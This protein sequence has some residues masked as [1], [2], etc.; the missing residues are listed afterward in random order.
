MLMP[1]V[2]WKEIRLAR[3][4][5]KQLFQIFSRAKK[6]SL[7]LHFC[8]PCETSTMSK[9]GFMNW[10]LK[11][12]FSFFSL[13]LFHVLASASEQP[14]IIFILSDDQGS[15][16]VGWRGSEIKTPHLDKLARAG[17]RLE[18]FYVQPLCSPTRAA[19]LTGRYPMRYGLQL[20]VIRPHS[21]YG[22]SLEE[23][24]LPQALREAGYTTALSGK[25]HLGT[26]TKDY[27]PNQR[28]FEHAYG[29]LFGMT[30]YFE[31]TRDGKL[32][33]WRNGKPNKDEGYATELIGRD[34]VE[35]IRKQPKDKPLF[36][37]VPFNAVHYPFQAPEKYKT[38]YAHMKEPRRTYAGMVAAMDEAIGKI[39]AAVDETGRRKNTLFI[40]SSDNGGYKPG[41]VT[42]NGPLRA[43]KGSVYEGGARTCAF[44]TWEGKIPAGEVNGL[45][46]I[47][48]W[49]P[50]LLNL[51]GA[52]LKQ[53][54]PLD[55]KDIWPTLAQGKPSPRTEVLINTIPSGGA[56]RMGDWKIVVQD[57]GV[58]RE[59]TDKVSGQKKKT[60]QTGPDGK[61]ELFN[62]A[63]DVSEKNNVAD[64][65]PKKL[66][67]LRAR[68]D[69]LAKQ[70]VPPIN[71]DEKEGDVPSL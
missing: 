50:T 55:G 58:T 1:H 46:H 16:D 5:E 52:S 63:D 41:E 21:Q 36:L 20:R 37:Y 57:G 14:D 34:A 4:R 48:D 45:M 35:I 39:V 18:N 11:K 68:Y 62:L 40:F 69:A 32:D 8:L 27:W 49:Y 33:W 53:K 31:H 71:A 25:W 24:T 12:L 65:Y 44:A 10:N 51:A 28:G 26:A 67:E 29:H 56:L 70:A 23:R 64:Q 3:R 6:S 47:V 9:I 7:P 30:D 19:L 66:K 54:L 61:T 59:G 13:I 2:E 42:D 15:Y 22:L 17:A 60:K 38:P 43:G